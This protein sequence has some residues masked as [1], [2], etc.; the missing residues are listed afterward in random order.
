MIYRLKAEKEKDQRYHFWSNQFENLASEIF[1]KFS[2]KDPNHCR[3]SLLIEI[4]SYAN[5]TPLHLAVLA[6]AKVFL[7]Q[8]PIHDVLTRIWFDE[9]FV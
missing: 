5:L 3:K 6:Q 4:P 8:K 2:F 9:N 7:T 1:E